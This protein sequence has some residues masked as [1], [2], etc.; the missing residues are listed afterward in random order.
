MSNNSL[1]YPDS[2]TRKIKRGNW[3]AAISKM[4]DLYNRDQDSNRLIE[5]RNLRLEAGEQLVRSGESQKITPCPP[6]CDNPF[7]GLSNEF[8]SIDATELTPDI[9]AGAIRHHGALI[10]RGF[11][12]KQFCERSRD[13]ID[14]ALSSAEK[15]YSVRPEVREKMLKEK[16]GQDIWFNLFSQ[17]KG[18]STSADAFMMSRTGAVW[19]FLSPKI[20]HNLTRFFDRAG[21]RP[22]LKKYFEDEPCLSLNKSVL[23][24][25]TPLENPADWH[26]DGAFMPSN[27]KSLNLWIAL[28]ECGEGTNC[29]GMDFVPRRFESVVETG[30]NGAY[31]D[32]S[33][34][35]RSVHEWYKD[36]PPIRPYFEEGD[37]IFFDHFNL[38]VTS[39]DETFTQPRYA[40]ETWFF[41]QNYNAGNQTPA[42]W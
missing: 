4:I 21:L 28:S 38:H 26:Q 35:H 32:W 42:Y 9:L 14:K 23:R 16:F 24:R 15:F 36:T 1:K 33:V 18:H 25:V 8:P 2:V 40:I 37:A 39:H 13:N 7:P 31:F 29:P 19:T 34:S 22:I 30:T 12:D 20:T 10:V 17:I 41:A 5:L 11:A 3:R 6:L 27:I